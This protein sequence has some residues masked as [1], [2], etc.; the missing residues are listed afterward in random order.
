MEKQN[1]IEKLSNPIR[2]IDNAGITIDV[3]NVCDRLMF[4]HVIKILA[5]AGNYDICD[6]PR[7]SAIYNDS[8]AT[9]PEECAGLLPK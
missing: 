7:V 8:V 1:D 6:I 3:D 2:R 9:I 5:R 4:I